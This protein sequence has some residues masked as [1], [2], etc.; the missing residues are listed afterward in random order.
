V[1]FYLV[2]PLPHP[3]A[4]SQAFVSLMFARNAAFQ[5]AA[6]LFVL[7][8]AFTAQAFV[9][10][11]MPPSSYDDV[12]RAHEA[13]ALTSTLHARLRRKLAA[14][15]ARGRKRTRANIMTPTG[16]IDAKALLGVL[17][18]GLFNYNTVE[19][20]LLAS[21]IVVC[22]LGILFA[23]SGVA[24]NPYAAGTSDAIGGLVMA[25]VV[26]TILYFATVV[27]T[28][29]AIMWN[30]A[31]R[32]RKLQRGRS[33]KGLKTAPGGSP[34]RP[35]SKS[36]K[37]G[38]GGAGGPGS[39]PNIGVVTQ[40]FNPIIM[41]GAGGS[42]GGAGVGDAFT[43]DRQALVDAVTATEKPPPQE[44]WSMLR[45]T[46][47]ATLQHN[48]ALAGQLEAA[49]AGAGVCTVCGS[50]LAPHGGGAGGHK[51]AFGPVAAGGGGG[52][53]EGGGGHAHGGGSSRALHVTPNPAAQLA[54]FRTPSHR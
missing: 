8:V 30:E 4:A 39:V 40:E 5:L 48:E 21:A 33:G 38:I 10:P 53:G 22:L 32:R 11:Y 28:E 42:S 29:V 13:A 51:A 24:D 7:F 3:A 2:P 17:M 37:G 26:I 15:E 16:K 54:A 52:G 44:L 35:G 46:F 14:V 20:V 1:C 34:G 23:S 49:L 25:V 50:S 47:L 27:F 6:C 45:A 19:Q 43:G 31:D 41:G 12:L 18:L 36:F 9:Q